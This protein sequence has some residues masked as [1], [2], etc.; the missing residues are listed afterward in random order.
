MQ[1]FNLR[2]DLFLIYHMG[3]SMQE[4]EEKN[5]LKLLFVN[6]ALLV[7]TWIPWHVYL[8]SFVSTVEYILI[9]NTKMVLQYK[10]LF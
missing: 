2:A 4:N 6:N 1:I 8:M 3:N 5:D 9:S 10:Y 7:K